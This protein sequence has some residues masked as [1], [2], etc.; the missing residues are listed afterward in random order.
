MNTKPSFVS[1]ETAEEHFRKN[2]GMIFDNP[3]KVDITDDSNLRKIGRFRAFAVAKRETH[4][5]CV[6][7]CFQPMHGG[8][9]RHGDRRDEMRDILAALSMIGHEIGIHIV[10]GGHLS[11]GVEDN[12]SGKPLVT[13][14]RNA[15]CDDEMRLLNESSDYVLIP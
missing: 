4:K 10:V 6:I 13:G 9:I 2:T 3:A 7:D 14:N 11:R 12:I 1:F 5:V 8:D 15:T